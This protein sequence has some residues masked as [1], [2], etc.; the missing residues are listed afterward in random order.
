ME[1]IG[2]QQHACEKRYEDICFVIFVIGAVAGLYQLLSGPVRFSN[3]YEMVSIAR[4]LAEHGRFA[5]PEAI[6]D[7]GPTAAN[8][9]LYPLYLSLF[10]RIF[11]MTNWVYLAASLSNIVANAFTASFLPRISRL[12]YGSMWPGVFGSV[13][14]LATMQLMPGWDTSLTVAG[15]LLFCLFSASHMKTEDRDI[16]ALLGGAIA[17]SLFLLNPASLLISLPWMAYRLFFRKVRFRQTAILLTTLFL[18]I[19]LW[20]GRNYLQLGSFATRTGMG[21]ALY[22]SNNDCAEPSFTAEGLSG[23]YQAHHPNRSLDEAKLLRSMG[24][25]GYDRK[26]HADAALWIKTHPAKFWG[27]TLSRFRDFWFPPVNE[28]AFEAPL[29]CVITALSIP[30]IWLMLKRRGPITLF[31]LF[32]LLV[33]PLMYYVVVSC[34]RYRDPVLW[35]SLLPAGYFIWGICLRLQESPNPPSTART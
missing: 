22:S 6:L 15:V 30:G 25:V 32:V 8:P 27:L 5:N 10:I 16:Y 29:I 14:W 24:E 18:I 3:N 20:A 17:G 23:C 19:F 28:Y 11:G 7:T 12:F 21:I 34:T 31:L 9:P 26:R 2:Q 4:N 35:L 1:E 13:L 33:Y